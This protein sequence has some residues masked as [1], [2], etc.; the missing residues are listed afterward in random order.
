M[1]IKKL[2]LLLLFVLFIALLLVSTY[3]AMLIIVQSQKDEHAF[4]TLAL[5]V[6]E[7]SFTSPYAGLKQENDDFFDFNRRY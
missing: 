4:K 3:K 2:I 6:K 1:K 5:S 7:E